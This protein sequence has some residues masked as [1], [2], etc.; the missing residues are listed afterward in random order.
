MGEGL[1]CLVT[2][3]SAGVLLSHH[4]TQLEKS[5]Q[6]TIQ[7]FHKNIELEFKCS[8]IGLHSALPNQKVI[9]GHKN[10]EL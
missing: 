3:A 10:I 7:H 8:G 4:L 5:S 9:P 2:G 6:D 1:I